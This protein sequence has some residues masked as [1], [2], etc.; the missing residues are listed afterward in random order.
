MIT[1]G[2]LPAVNASLHPR[3]CAMKIE[4][5]VIEKTEKSLLSFL[6]LLL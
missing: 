5:E 4:Q 2:V 6:R 1:A 3:R